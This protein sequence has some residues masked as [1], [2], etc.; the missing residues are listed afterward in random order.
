[1]KY[2]G[3]QNIIHVIEYS[4]Y[5]EVKTEYEKIFAELEAAL[6]FMTMPITSKEPT[7]KTLLET[8]DED[9]KRGREA[10]QKLKEFK[11]QK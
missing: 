7:I 11:G 9:T 5:E 10:L 4:A 1:M 3:Y 8:F 2:A 6:E